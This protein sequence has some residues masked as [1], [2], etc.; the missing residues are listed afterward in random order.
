MFRSF[1]IN[2]IFV[3]MI[4]RNSYKIVIDFYFL[5]LPYYILFYLLKDRDFYFIIDILFLRLIKN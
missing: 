5:S 1:K 3:R 2:L 4:F